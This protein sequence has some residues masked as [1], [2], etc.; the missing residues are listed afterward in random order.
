MVKSYLIEQ[1]T[2]IITGNISLQDFIIAKEV[3]LGTY[4]AKGTLPPGAHLSV[5]KMNEDARAEP[6]YGERVPFV[7]V[8][9][10]QGGSRLID[11]VVSPNEL[12]RDR[13]LRLHATYYITKQIIPALSRIFNLIGA[14]L[15]NWYEKM[16]KVQ[17]TIHFA[18]QEAPDARPGR[19]LDQFYK[20]QHCIVCKGLSSNGKE[21]CSVCFEKKQE[22]GLILATELNK[23]ESKHLISQSICRSCTSFSNLI[24][25]SSACVSLDCPIYYSRVKATQQVKLTEKLKRVMKI[26]DEVE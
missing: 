17:K 23:M 10:S 9:N 16:P 26:L 11:S 24:D 1:W 2:K 18:S 14:D 19:T 6:Q 7:V 20:S 4:S 25:A 3:K 21:I 22:S 13:S 15:M 5:K 8:Y 12:L